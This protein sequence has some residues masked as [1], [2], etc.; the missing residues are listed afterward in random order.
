MILA[1]I[2][3][4]LIVDIHESRPHASSA[5]EFQDSLKDQYRHSNGIFI[6]QLNKTIFNMKQSDIPLTKY[7]ANMKRLCGDIVVL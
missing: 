6:F 5:K 3:N 1:W 7:C 2:K 4:S